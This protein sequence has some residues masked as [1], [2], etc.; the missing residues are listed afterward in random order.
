M[1]RRTYVKVDVLQAIIAM[2]YSIHVIA[3]IDYEKFKLY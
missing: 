3:I 2:S 1:I